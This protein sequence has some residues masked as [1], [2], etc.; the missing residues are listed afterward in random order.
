MC[1]TSGERNTHTHTPEELT[2]GTPKMKVWLRF[3]FP[4]SQQVI[5]RFQPVILQGS[6][7]VHTVDGSIRFLWTKSPLKVGAVKFPM[8]F[9]S[10]GLV[11][12][13][14][15][16]CICLEGGRQVALHPKWKASTILD[17]RCKIRG[18]YMYLHHKYPFHPFAYQWLHHSTDFYRWWK[19][20]QTTTLWMYKT[21]VKNG[22]FTI[23]TGQPDFWTIHSMTLC[24]GPPQKRCTLIWSQ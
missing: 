6:I 11:D 8:I 9:F 24:Y 19:K 7:L 5:F 18:W 12:H 21:L 16:K 13:H 2:A 14:R 23:S 4:F 22:I 3:D 10:S 17:N 20:S 1:Q 15:F